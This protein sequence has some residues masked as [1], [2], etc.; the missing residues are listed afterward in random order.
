MNKRRLIFFSIFGF[1]HL[2]LFI[3]TAYIDA[4]KED[5]SVLLKVSSY[6]S[7]FKWGALLGL[8]LL[9]ADA[10]WWWIESRSASREREASRL[11]NNTLKAKV[12]DFQ[13]SAKNQPLKSVTNSPS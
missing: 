12:Y 11:E 5:L 10:S 4:Q 7:L 1:Y 13:E 8:L 2:M 6:L 9:I 3:F